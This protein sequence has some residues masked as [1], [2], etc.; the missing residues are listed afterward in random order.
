MGKEAASS[1]V[2]SH[3]LA[4][5]AAGLAEANGDKELSGHLRARAKLSLITM[6]DEQLWELARLTSGG[7]T[8]EG[9]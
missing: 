7:K 1:Y 3:L 5:L 8:V 2:E 6:S 9:A 4:A